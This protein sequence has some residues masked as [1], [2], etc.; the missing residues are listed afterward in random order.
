MTKCTTRPIL[1]VMMI[2]VC[3]SVSIGQSSLY[4]KKISIRLENKPLRYVLEEIS[5]KSDVE[6]IF[7]DRLI[8]G[9]TVTC[10]LKNITVEEALE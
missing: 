8:D 7:D 3:V 5:E 2:L 10:D 1:T 9:K 6:F 4:T